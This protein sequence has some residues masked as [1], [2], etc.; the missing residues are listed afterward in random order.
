[1]LNPV[2]VRAA[3][4]ISAL[5]MDRA[6]QL[7]ALRQGSSALSLHTDP[8]LYVHPTYL[9][10]I[11]ADCLQR[12]EEELANTGPYTRLE[13]L[14]I[15]SIQQSCAEADIDLKAE[16]VLLIIS[17]TKGNID[18]L[19]STAA[20][21]ID[22]SRARLGVMAETVRKHFGFQHKAMIISNACI[23]GVMAQI[24]AARMIRA[25]KFKHVV[26]C[27]VDILS[28]FVIS[29]FDCLKAIDSKPCQPFDAERNG[30]TLG[31]AA[32]TLV[33][34]AMAK[35][36]SPYEH[37]EVL[38]GSISNDANHISGP[39]R[40]GDG[41]S[42]SIGL[43][44]KESGIAAADIDYI[45]AHGTATLYN[46]AMEAKAIAASGLMHASINSFKG[47]IGHTLGA[48]GI[49]E[50]IFAMESMMHQELYP[51][52]GYIQAGV[53][54]ALDICKEHQSKRIKYSLKLSSGF[55]GCN[56]TIIF[57]K[58]GL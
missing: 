55:G 28:E 46:D 4:S 49:I 26:L 8:S 56:A 48:A 15:H 5:G 36:G 34:S 30:V 38:G 14:A 52:A 51:S 58:A 18:L 21:G 17:T 29:G 11:P 24:M 53:E 35:A 31:E 6:S 12:V 42:H 16:D 44:L 45:S 13:K 40:T 20:R 2:F 54:E 22:S 9:G 41:L 23:S 43:S 7:S 47:Y 25:G 33:Y 37:I 27:G 10:S 19:Q 32:A 3:N 57:K 50:S 1:M 39:S